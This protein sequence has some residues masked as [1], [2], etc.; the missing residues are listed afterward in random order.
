[1]AYF[2]AELL[3]DTNKECVC[4]VDILGMKN[5][6]LSSLSQASNYIFKLHATILKLWRIDN[7]YVI[8]IYPVIDGAYITSKS[9]KLLLKF[10][11]SM[12]TELCTSLLKEDFEHWYL[13]RSS[14]AYGHIIHRR[15]IPYNASREFIS[16]VGYK[17]HLLL[18][19]AMV[20]AYTGEHE[21]APM[22]VY[23][24]ESMGEK[25][26]PRKYEHW[27]WYREDTISC[28]KLSLFVKRLNEYYDDL[29]KDGDLKSLPDEKKKCIRDK[30]DTY[31]KL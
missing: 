14:V 27:K 30:I 11:A 17:E 26:G 25:L 6:M 21:A 28:E 23:L 15:D 12:Y 29:F 13:V 20:R 1:M 10:I 16:S 19:E 4:F 3:P 2:N 8:S 18:G 9:K 7:P 22:G 31:F 24:D 5:K